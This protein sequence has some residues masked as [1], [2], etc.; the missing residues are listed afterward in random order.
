MRIKIS[1][2]GK[3]VEKITFEEYTSLTSKNAIVQRTPPMIVEIDY[4]NA[5]YGG[6][7]PIGDKAL[8]KAIAEM[9]GGQFSKN[10]PPDVNACIVGESS[11][12]NITKEEV[13]NLKFV[14][15]GPYTRTY[16]PIVFYREDVR[17]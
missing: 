7:Q 17:E 13:E 10:I 9:W 4:D 2:N 3:T 8:E 6:G 11:W 16:T 15:R 5:Q 14:N 12:H 1:V